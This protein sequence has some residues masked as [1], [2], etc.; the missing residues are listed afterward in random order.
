MHPLV[1]LLDAI[2][3][4]DFVYYTL[5]RAVTAICLPCF[6]AAR[7][8]TSSFIGYYSPDIIMEGNG[9]EVQAKKKK[10]T[11]T[12]RRTRTTTLGN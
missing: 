9:A 5:L 4:P 6:R 12:R 10:R 8:G 11:K 7:M 2:F 1:C 3:R